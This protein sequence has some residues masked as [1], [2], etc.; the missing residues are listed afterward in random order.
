M[1]KGMLEFENVAA[2]YGER[3]VL[4]DITLSVGEGE[5]VGLIGSNG[6]GKSTLIKCISGLLSVKRGKITVC[7]RDNAGLKAKERAK[8]VAVV[9]QSYHVEYDFTVEDIVMMGRNPYMSLRKREGKEDYEIVEDAMR[10][11][12]TEMFRERYYNELSGGERQ[13]VILARAIAQKTKVILLDEPTSAL[14]IHHQIEVMELITKLNK[15]EHMTI[16]AVLHDINMAS[17]FCRR[18]VM[19][20]DGAVYADGTPKEVITR[21]N[22][23]SLYRMKLMIRQNPLFCKPEIVPIRVM[24][25][26]KASVRRHIHM[27]CGA[28]GAGKLLEELDARGYY[29]T[30]GVLNQGSTDYDMCQEL[31]IPCVET[32]PFTPVTEEKQRENLK[33]MQD[34]DMIV[35]AD[36]PFGEDNLN[37]L[38]GLETMSGK[39]YFHKNALSNDF[40]G[41]GLVRRLE[42][43]AKTKKI[44]YFGDHDEFLEMLR[45]EETEGAV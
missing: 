10:A 29:V 28:N 27:I 42:E 9:P 38:Y 23:E 13:R 16:L 30:A 33:L 24:E 25:E 12:N 45:K 7:G 44:S 26:E 8:L 39:I 37:N 3:E 6:T 22:M 34:A 1:D 18:I 11:T 21:R 14:D 17:R 31:G 43:M 32:E 20:K 4:K 36:V 5:F 15:E 35:V 40:T 19:L 41:G 2:G